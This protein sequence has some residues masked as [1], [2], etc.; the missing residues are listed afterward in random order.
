[1]E[2]F[3]AEAARALLIRG[4]DVVDCPLSRAEQAAL[5]GNGLGVDWEGVEAGAYADPGLVPRPPLGELAATLRGHE[6]TPSGSLPP[7]GQLPAPA[8]SAP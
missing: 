3:R 7:P 1:M 8:A 6:A 5:S 2:E 4:I